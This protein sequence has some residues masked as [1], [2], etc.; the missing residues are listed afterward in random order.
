MD[1]L[2]SAAFAIL[3]DEGRDALAVRR[4]ADDLGIRAPSLYKHVTDKAAL[5]A[6]LIEDVLFDIGDVLHAALVRADEA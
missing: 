1:E 5:E 4:L 2:V 6:A 3:D